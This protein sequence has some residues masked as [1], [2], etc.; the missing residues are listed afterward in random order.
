VAVHRV[1]VVSAYVD[2]LRD[3]AWECDE[4]GLYTV[5]ATRSAPL[6]LPRRSSR[7]TATGCRT[8]PPAVQSTAGG[9]PVCRASRMNSA[10][11]MKNPSCIALPEGPTGQAAPT[12][13][14]TA[15]NVTG[16]A[17][18]GHG[19]TVLREG[20]PQSIRHVGRRCRWSAT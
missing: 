8:P 5:E 2:E 19:P 15:S 10:L 3:H 18:V 7:P 16:L 20:V 1:H 6:R 9:T 4:R 17:I 14:I 13:A 11:R 12:N